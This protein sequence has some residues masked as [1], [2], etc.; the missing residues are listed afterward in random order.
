MYYRSLVSSCFLIGAGISFYAPAHAAEDAM[1]IC[2]AAISDYG[3]GLAS[4][5]PAKLAA[6]YAPDGELVSPWGIVSGHD[7]L[8]KNFASYMKPGDK[9]VDTLA[10]ARMIGDLVLCT[11]D[12]TFTPASG[13]SGEKG[14]WTKVGGKVGGEWKILNLTYATAAPQ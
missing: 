8:V 12:Y 2:K 3:A 13:G 1:A 10:S 4:G 9:G 11:G 5:D 14:F 7:A 6:V